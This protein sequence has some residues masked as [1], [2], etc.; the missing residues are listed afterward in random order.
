MTDL[1]P[2]FDLLYDLKTVEQLHDHLTGR[3]R[4]SISSTDAEIIESCHTY[5]VPLPEE[6]ITAKDSNAPLARTVSGLSTLLDICVIQESLEQAQKALWEQTLRPM[7]ADCKTSGDARAVAQDILKMRVDH[8]GT[9]LKL[10]T[11]ID[12]MMD[13][14]VARIHR[15]SLS[16]DGP[17]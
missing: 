4:Y 1:H 8:D 14:E 12:K 11:L 16:N 7:F 3:L 13:A 9:R 2:D 10:P 17:R 6:L 5:G 15:A